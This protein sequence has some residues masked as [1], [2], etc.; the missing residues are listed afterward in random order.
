[1]RPG[2]SGE[3][4]DRPIKWT[5]CGRRS[6]SQAS[7]HQSHSRELS[8]PLYLPCATRRCDP[9][10]DGRETERDR[11]MARGPSILN[12]PSSHHSCHSSPFRS[13]TCKLSTIKSHLPKY[14]ISTTSPSDTSHPPLRPSLP[15]PPPVPLVTVRPAER[16]LWSTCTAT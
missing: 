9:A 1:M 6:R 15:P 11:P 5:K 3:F 14:L 16:H 10:V 7:G 8:S 13:A 2:R 12:R 4:D